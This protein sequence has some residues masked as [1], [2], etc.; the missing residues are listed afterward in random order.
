[1]CSVPSHTL[2]GVNLTASASAIGYAT[3]GSLW[4]YCS[5]MDEG[6]PL[7]VAKGEKR[8]SVDSKVMVAKLFNLV[9]ETPFIMKIL[10][11]TVRASSRYDL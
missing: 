1:M 6:S 4:S 7:V 10:W 8:S 5:V 3:S 11:T 9:F 2:G